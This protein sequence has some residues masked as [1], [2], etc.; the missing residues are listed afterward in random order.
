[1]IYGLFW[2]I[3]LYLWILTSI[4][5]I[6]IVGSCNMEVRDSEVFGASKN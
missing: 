6:P 5:I 2:L 1:M 3:E 4:A